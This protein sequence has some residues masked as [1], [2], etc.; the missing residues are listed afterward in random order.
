MTSPI[1]DIKPELLGNRA[2]VLRLV[3]LLPYN[4]EILGS[5][6]LVRLI[7]HLLFIFSST[8][9]TYLISNKNMN[10]LWLIIFEKRGTSRSLL[11]PKKKN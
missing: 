3:S 4:I 9:L 8:D 1:V 6:S 5:I 7:V 10:K 2:R 11:N